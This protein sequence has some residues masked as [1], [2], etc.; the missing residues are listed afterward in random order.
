MQARRT[1]HGPG[2]TLDVVLVHTRNVGGEDGSAD[3]VP[4]WEKK[5]GQCFEVRFSGFK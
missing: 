2:V 4:E 5:D 1:G 3:G